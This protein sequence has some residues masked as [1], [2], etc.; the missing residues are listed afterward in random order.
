MYFYKC[1]GCLDIWYSEELHTKC[2][3]FKCGEEYEPPT[4][5]VDEWV[6]RAMK[7]CRG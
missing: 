7:R 2:K 1:P 5:Q 6:I 3:C 4:I